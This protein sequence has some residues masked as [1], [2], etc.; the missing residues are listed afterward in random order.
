MS[1]VVNTLSSEEVASIERV[2]ATTEAFSVKLGV[3]VWEPMY[4]LMRV[5]A[6]HQILLTRIGQLEAQLEDAW[7]ALSQ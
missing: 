2:A 4:D 7:A 1:A 6:S 5:C 3:Y